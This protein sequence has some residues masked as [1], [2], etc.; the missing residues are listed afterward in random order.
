MSRNTLPLVFEGR[1]YTLGGIDYENANGLVVF[2]D[3]LGVKGIWKTNDPAKVLQNWNQ[4]YYLFSDKLN[5]LQG[6]HLSAFS[7][8]FIISVRGH[9]RLN[10]QPWRFIEMICDSIVPAFVG[11]MDYN[12]FLRGVIASGYF[13]RST[14]SLIGPAVDEAANYY[15]KADWVGISLS[16]STCLRLENSTVYTNSNP[17]VSYRIPQAPGDKLMTCA[18]NWTK[19]DPS[20]KYWNILVGKAK[21]YVHDYRKSIKYQNALDFYRACSRFRL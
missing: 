9:T 11:S 16:P 2:L 13:S 14:K 7:D 4:V 10:N 20:Y 1:H 12:F 18:V 6:V 8:T 21:K 5:S 3:A 19:W 15:E 17:I